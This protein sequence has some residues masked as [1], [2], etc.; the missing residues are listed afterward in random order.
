MKK[1]IELPDPVAVEVFKDGAPVLNEDGTTKTITF[2]ALDFACNEMTRSGAFTDAGPKGLAA[3]CRVEEAILDAVE[4]KASHY[5]VHADD[6]DRLMAHIN[7][8]KDGHYFGQ[9]AIGPRNMYKFV[10][11]WLVATNV[12]EQGS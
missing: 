11:P 10:K 3:W 8:P 5:D 1:R 12:E 4:A 7:D 6:Y 9:N 2:T